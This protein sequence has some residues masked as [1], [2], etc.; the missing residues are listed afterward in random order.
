[1]K[2]FL[3]TLIFL[4]QSAWAIA[5]NVPLPGA[6]NI[7]GS[8]GEIGDITS[9][10]SPDDLFDDIIPG[11]LD[12]PSEVKPIWDRSE[13]IKK[14]SVPTKG[15]AYSLPQ[16]AGMTTGYNDEFNDDNSDLF[17]TKSG[18]TVNHNAL[19]SRNF[20]QQEYLSSIPAEMLQKNYANDS[21]SW[22]NFK[23]LANSDLADKYGAAMYQEP[24]QAA[25][26]MNVRTAAQQ[27][28]LQATQRRTLELLHNSLNR[29]QSPEHRNEKDRCMA[30]N[31]IG[32]TN[33][34]ALGMNSV[35]Y[36]DDLF[37]GL[38]GGLPGPLPGL[39]GGLDAKSY[40][41]AKKICE[42][43]AKQEEYL[44]STG[45]WNGQARL[46]SLATF[47]H[48]TNSSL[49]SIPG[50][51]LPG[52]LG[53]A[54]NFLGDKKIA[55]WMRAQF[56]DVETRIDVS[57]N[58]LN[59][60][61]KAVALKTDKIAPSFS[62]KDDVWSKIVTYQKNSVWPAFWSKAS[63]GGYKLSRSTLAKITCNYKLPLSQK[64]A[65]A[66][67]KGIP[68]PMRP[69]VA[70]Y[71]ARCA[72]STFV[73]N[74]CKMAQ[75]VTNLAVSGPVDDAEINDWRNRVNMICGP[76]YEWEAEYSTER[77]SQV[78]AALESMGQ[79]ALESHSEGVTIHAGQSGSGSEDSGPFADFGG[80]SAEDANSDSFGNFGNIG[81]IIGGM[82]P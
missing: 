27:Q 33:S 29:D 80:A 68:P 12:L 30:L 74:T 58:L 60:D 18:S 10:L 14:K 46:S 44:K 76:V 8:L 53:S 20:V 66:M 50:I 41:E 82:L 11:N 70:D 62:L 67:D 25:I 15:S 54:L 64:L 51:S 43:K 35:N 13:A 23:D 28:D 59:A 17:G 79:K 49:F 39:G 32:Q 52:G 2:K 75:H 38:V 31:M 21:A 78:F 69:I 65:D 77:L 81:N 72:A 45:G 57:F 34:A 40:Q 42:A 47:G 4:S 63:D 1:M 26:M 5:P 7:P 19:K 22:D 73:N 36:G 55:N 71:F 56:G 61:A 24:T 48:L 9:D 16:I 3:L 6:G 37:G